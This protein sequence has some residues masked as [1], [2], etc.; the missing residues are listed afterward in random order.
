MKGWARWWGELALARWDY[1]VITVVI[2]KKLHRDQYQVWHFLPYHYCLA[3][4]LERFV[5]FLHYGNYRGDVMIESRGGQED[6]KLK[7]S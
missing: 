4:L 7:D 5:L 6:H 1:R 2:D 3:V